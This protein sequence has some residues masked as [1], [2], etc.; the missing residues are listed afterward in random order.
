LALIITGLGLWLLFLVGALV[1]GLLPRARKAGM[2]SMVGL[3][4]TML[5]AAQNFF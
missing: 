2:R 4:A 5:V 1:I 3:G